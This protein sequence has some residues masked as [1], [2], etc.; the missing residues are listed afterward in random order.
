MDQAA[1]IKVAQ[2]D[3]D[4]QHKGE[5][6]MAPWAH[7]SSGHQGRDATYRWAYEQG[8]DLTMDVIAQVIHECETCAV[9]KQPNG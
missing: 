1:K 5:Q 8:V 4:W 6:F 2:V 3:L 7:D 9:I